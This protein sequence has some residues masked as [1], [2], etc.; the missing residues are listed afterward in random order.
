MLQNSQKTTV[1][2]A[3]TLDEGR[4]TGRFA[5]GDEIEFRIAFENVFSPDRYFATPAVARGGGMIAWIDR[6]EQ[7]TSVV[8]TGTRDTD[9]VVDIPFDI[10]IDREVVRA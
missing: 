3:S 7:H 6:R 5:A 2:A 4:N 1:L 8:V 10:S 9:A